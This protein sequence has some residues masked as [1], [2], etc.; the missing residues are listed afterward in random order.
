MLPI[1]M[2]VPRLTL[3]LKSNSTSHTNVIYK[4]RNYL[5]SGRRLG[6]FERHIN[7]CRECGDATIDYNQN[8]NKFSF[9]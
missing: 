4:T 7:L 2:S 6:L 9:D 3:D 1:L 8:P 5:E